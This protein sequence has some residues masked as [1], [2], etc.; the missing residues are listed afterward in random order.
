MERDELRFSL[1]SPEF[2]LNSFGRRAPSLWA[3]TIRIRAPNGGIAIGGVAIVA[4]VGSFRN[5][6]GVRTEPG[7]EVERFGG[8]AVD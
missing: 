3:K 1:P 6:D 4:Q 5:E 8:T 2:L 7:S